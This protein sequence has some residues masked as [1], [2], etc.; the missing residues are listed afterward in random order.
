MTDLPTRP[1]NCNIELPSLRDLR[2]IIEGSDLVD[3]RRYLTSE[4]L[5]EIDCQKL[6][7]HELLETIAYLVKPSLRCIRPDNSVETCR[8]WINTKFDLYLTRE[9]AEELWDYLWLQK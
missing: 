4:E 2:S 1:F 6:V 7:S 9:M 8:K 3:I 5:K